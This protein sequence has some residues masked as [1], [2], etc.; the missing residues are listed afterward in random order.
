MN[1]YSLSVD[2]RS[3]LTHSLRSMD[4]LVD[5]VCSGLEARGITDADY[6]VEVHGP[7]EL[8]IGVVER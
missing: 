8:R 7:P 1:H 2:I 3:D 5:I 6:Y 4:D